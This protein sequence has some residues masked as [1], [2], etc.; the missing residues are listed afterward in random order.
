MLRSFPGFLSQNRSRW[1]RIRY[2]GVLGT[3]LELHFLAE[4]QAAREAER[5]ALAEIERL[6]GLYSRYRPDSELNRWQE[7]LTEAVSPD[8]AGLLRE[9]ER[10]QERTAGAFNPGVEAV[11]RLYRQNPDPSEEQ[12]EAL[13]KALGAPLWTW[14][15]ETPHKRTPLELNFNALAKGRIADL[16]C[17][18]AMG[19]EGVQGACVNLGGDL[20]HRGPQGMPVAITSPFSSADNAPALAQIRIRNQ[21]VATSGH[22]QRG[23]HLFDPRRAQPV[24]GV[25]QATVVAGDAATADV[26]ATVFCVLE[27]Q[28][29]LRLAEQLGVAGLIVSRS[30]ALH[31]NPQFQALEE[32]L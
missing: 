21:G 32:A 31:S 4:P 14:E 23:P 8:L 10:W 24:Q 2:E 28:E 16:A 13:L 25:A 9:A 5:R 20:S 7:G 1:R 12:R 17:A 22:T 18:A 30:G 27:P 26:L 3:A 29:S 19:V 6:E 11:Q 15:G